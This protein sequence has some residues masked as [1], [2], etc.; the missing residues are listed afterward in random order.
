[1][2]KPHWTY[3]CTDQDFESDRVPVSEV[4][5]CFMS[6][7]ASFK[8]MR[9]VVPTECERLRK[10]VADKWEFLYG[11]AHGGGYS[12][13]PRCTWALSPER[14]KTFAKEYKEF[15]LYG[16]RLQEPND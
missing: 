6:L 7:R 16:L 13:D 12:L 11:D 3:H 10:Y 5:K 9:E 14:K 2:G 1:M 4:F 8:S 15:Q